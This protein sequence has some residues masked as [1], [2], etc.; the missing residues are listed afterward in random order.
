MLFAVWGWYVG[1]FLVFVVV[2]LGCL[3]CLVLGFSC[4]SFVG[5]FL[6]DVILSAEVWSFVLGV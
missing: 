5:G 1:V 2:V 4:L 6:G 3:S